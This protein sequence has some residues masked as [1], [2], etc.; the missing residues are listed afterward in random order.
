MI[1]AMTKLTMTM[2][3]TTR[4]TG[5]K[6]T[7]TALKRINTNDITVKKYYI[8][9]SQTEK[10]CFCSMFLLLKDLPTVYRFLLMLDITQP[11]SKLHLRKMVFNPIQ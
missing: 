5:I 4:T 7:T 2:M 1:T 3:T 6:V 11:F 8:Y 9:N 10:N